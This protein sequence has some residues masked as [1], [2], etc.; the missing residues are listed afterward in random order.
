M[1]DVLKFIKK[2]RSE[3][4]RLTV[5]FLG[6]GKTNLALIRRLGSVHGVDFVYRDSHREIPS[7]LPLGTRYEGRAALT[8]IDEDVLFIAPSIRRDA[9]ELISAAERGVIL[10]SDSEVFFDRTDMDIYAVSG[11]DGKSSTVYLTAQLLSREGAP[12]FPLGNFG[13]PL[14]TYRGR[15]PCAVE[16]SSFN[17]QYLTPKT[18]RAA[19]TNITENHLDWHAS[20][21]EYTEAK[22]RLLIGSDEPV[23][24]ADCA[25]SRGFLTDISPFA[26]TSARMSA[27]ELSRLS[28]CEVLTL[29]D[30]IIYHF[31][32]PMLDTRVMKRQLLYDKINM[33]N[34]LALT[35]FEADEDKIY[36]VAS[37]FGGLPDRAE[38]VGVFRGISC[39]SSSIDTTPVRTAATLNSLGRR[40][41]LLL[42]GRSKSLPLEPLL[43]ALSRYGE[44]V[45]LFGEAKEEF[46][47]E[48]TKS[49]I[50][51][52][53][54]PDF[55]EA[56][57][58]AL[59][60]AAEGDTVLLSPAA[61]SYD[62][63]CD[64]SA[65]GTAFKR[66]VKN[67]FN[68]I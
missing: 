6:I 25:I 40:V 43:P 14:C 50:D 53:C 65:R 63:F 13:T 11:S 29:R 10:T 68:E 59:S 2:M 28:E 41:H 36:S 23:I 46:A 35:L 61:T 51:Y 38:T 58:H 49:G 52:T 64:Y 34:A 55:S 32:L 16:L 22:K 19:I 5:G 27:K 21:G 9:R 24:N 62:E 66:I 45:T 57:C 60:R 31:D 26:L 20:F 37:E 67:Y 3:R 8:N 48:L 7:G 44:S 39:I 15:G 54:C 42:G 30:G 12:V 47:R 1:A 56:V 17:L 33:M 4:G 18:R